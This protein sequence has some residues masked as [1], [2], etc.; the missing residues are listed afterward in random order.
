MSIKKPTVNPKQKCPVLRFGF[1]GI[2]VG[3]HTI[4][5]CLRNLEENL[6]KKP[7]NQDNGVYEIGA[8]DYGRD[9]G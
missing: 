8:E 2:E 1:Y 3:R 9:H 7:E 5:L 4:I 6:E